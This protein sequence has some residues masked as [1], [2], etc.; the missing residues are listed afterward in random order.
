ME[1]KEI[2][3]KYPTIID[4]LGMEFTVCYVKAS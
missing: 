3:N 1:T 2:L 4:G